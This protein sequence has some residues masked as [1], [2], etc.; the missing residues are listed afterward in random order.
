MIRLARAV[1]PVVALGI[2]CEPTPCQKPLDQWCTHGS[3]EVE[4][5]E[6]LSIDPST[7]PSCGAYAT[8]ESSAGYTGHTHYFL[9][10]EHVATRYWGDVDESCGTESWYGKPVTCD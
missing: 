9:D 4:A 8:L 7:P 10:G 6:P 3:A 5:C 1:A 2:A